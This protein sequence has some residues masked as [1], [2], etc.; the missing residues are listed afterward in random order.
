MGT[1]QERDKLLEKARA[2]DT[3][4]LAAL[5]EQLTPELRRRIAAKMDGP[6]RSLIDEDDILQVT[7][8]EACTRLEKF[9]GGGSSGFLA[10]LTR[11]ADN[12][13]IDAV[14][15][16]EGAKRPGPSKRVHAAEADDSALALIELMG[17][18]SH[19]P[20]RSVAR[21]EARKALDQALGA[22]PTEYERVIRL[23]DLKGKSAAEVGAEMG[24]S[25]GAVYMLR[26]RAHERLREALGPGSRFFST[27]A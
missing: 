18:T 14:R 1:D 22:I 2:G 27:P 21:G 26:A 3:K 5:L 8:I 9:T 25:E 12:N 16:L 19:T 11:M 6:W 15:S 10:W 4:A 23:Y 13:R 20:S 17:G 24:R 7:F